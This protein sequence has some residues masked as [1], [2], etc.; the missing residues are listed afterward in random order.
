MEAAAGRIDNGGFAF[1]DKEYQRVMYEIR[2]HGLGGQG[3]VTMATWVAKAGYATGKH[4]QA[5]PFFGAER[6][7][8]PVKA[9]ARIDE[10]PINLRSQ[11]YDPDLLVVTSPNLLDLALGDGFSKHGHLLINCGEDLAK[12]LAGEYGMDIYYLDAVSIAIDAGLE[13]DGMPMVNIP[14]FSAV[15]KQAELCSFEVVRDILD[16]PSRRGNPDDYMAAALKGFEGVKKAG[17]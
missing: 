6:R 7:G 12:R 15:I 14:L 4:V 10:N 2:V 3:S 8:A 17:P 9:F 13:Y 5:F 11:V 16:G 1:S